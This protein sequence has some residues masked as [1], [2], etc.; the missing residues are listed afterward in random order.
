MEQ[1]PN[2]SPVNPLPP[3]IVAL[4]L[5]F[6]VIEIAVTLGSKG[7]I[8]GPQAVG[9]RIALVSDYAPSGFLLDR[10]IETHTYTPDLLLRFVTYAF[11]HANFT[12]MVFSVVIL[13][14][15]GKV[16]GEV[17]KGWAV[18]VVFFASSI[19]AAVIYGLLISSRVPLIGAMPG[20]YGLIG[21]F[22]FVLWMS[23]GLHNANRMR[24][25]SLI[26]FL[27]GIQLVFGVLFGSTQ[28]WIADLS[29]FA[30]GFLVSFIVSPGGWGRLLDK[31]RQRS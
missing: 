18:L 26:G 3:V 31:M 6:A 27:M 13:L 8:G 17:F 22:T 25:F 14:A 29:G 24:A 30:I 21:A 11:I 19:G 2:I 28:D 23:L 12:H 16:V 7:L 20:V 9:W 4:A 15:M 5:A 10:M 1:D